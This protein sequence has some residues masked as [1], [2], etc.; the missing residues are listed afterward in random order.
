MTTLTA[1]PSPKN[2]PAGNAEPASEQTVVPRDLCDRCRCPLPT[3]GPSASGDGTT[4]TQ[5]SSLQEE[6]ASLLPVLE[7]YQ[8]LDLE[9][10]GYHARQSDATARDG[11]LHAAINEARAFLEALVIGIALEEERPP[12][13]SIA[14]FRKRRQSHYGFPS[15][16]N[17]LREIGF[18]NHHERVTIQHV[19]DAASDS[20][21]H[22]GVS[23]EAWCCCARR[24]VW[25]TAHYVI[26]R[27][28]AWQS[29]CRCH[30]A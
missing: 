15:C 23:S 5:D 20:G 1:E 3:S 22:L 2:E 7:R 13:E 28:E 26:Q 9:T 18:F 21:S 16:N 8:E 19:Y 25:T 10:L 30:P 4:T 12:E 27:Y 17:Y 29:G 14:D 24:I 11:Y 6:L